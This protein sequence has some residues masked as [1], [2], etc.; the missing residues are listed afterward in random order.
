M[1]SSDNQ[2]PRHFSRIPF[3]ADILLEIHLIDAVHTAQLIDISLKGALVKTA[4]AIPE[5]I[6]GRNCSMTLT[7][8]DITHSDCEK[9]TMQGKVAHHEGMLLGIECLHTDIDSMTNLRRLIELNIGDEVLLHQEIGEM[10]K[11]VLAE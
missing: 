5:Y 9:I 11:R 8:G 2:Q 1:N 4:Q 10:L 3:R 7:L 6:H